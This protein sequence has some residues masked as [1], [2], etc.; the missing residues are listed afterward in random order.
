MLEKFLQVN[1]FLTL[2][3]LNFPVTASLPIITEQSLI[4]RFV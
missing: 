3:L 2:L 4:L 1:F